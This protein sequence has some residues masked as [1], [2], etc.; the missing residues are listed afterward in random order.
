MILYLNTWLVVAALTA[1]PE[2]LR[3]QNWLGERTADDLLVSDWVTVEFSAALSMKLRRREIDQIQRAHALATYRKLCDD[4]ITVLPVYGEH[5]G[6]A[7]RFSDQ[8]AIGLRAGDA[9]HLAI[10]D[11]HGARLCTLDRRQSDAGP[12]LGVMTQLV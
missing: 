10:S 12:P 5:F 1:E 3:V 11:Q 8:S 7:T 4:T 9:L 2:T 6:V